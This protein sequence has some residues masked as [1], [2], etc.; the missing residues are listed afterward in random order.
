MCITAS[1]NYLTSEIQLKEIDMTK[2][3]AEKSFMFTSD[4]LKSGAKQVAILTKSGFLKNHDLLQKEEDTSKQ[5]FYF[6]V[7]NDD[8]VAA[9]FYI[10]RQRSKCGMECTTRHIRNKR[11]K[12]CTLIMESEA[13]YDVYYIPTEKMKP[14]TT[15]HNKGKLAMMV[16]RSH[17]DRYQNIEEMNRML[18]DNFKFKF[19]K[20]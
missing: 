2:P 10:G 7:G 18:S 1:M 17:N 4:L 20:F 3:T 6:L 13:Q 12:V 11:S 9:R 15:G 16:T 8:V 19:Q 5:G 14:L